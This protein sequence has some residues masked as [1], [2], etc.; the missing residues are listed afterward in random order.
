M[1]GEGFVRIK[2]AGLGVALDRG[3]ELLRV[4]CLESGAKPRQLPRG[5]LFNGFLD[6]FGDGHT[7][8]IAFAGEA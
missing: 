1:R 7:K 2:L 6:V 3:V 5:E 4:E 8:E